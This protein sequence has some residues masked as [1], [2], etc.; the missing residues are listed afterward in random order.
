NPDWQERFDYV[1]VVGSVIS[2]EDERN[3]QML[4]EFY[5]VLKPGGKLYGSFPSIFWDLETAYLSQE[6]AYWLTDGSINLSDSAV[7]VPE[8]NHREIYYT[9]LRLNRIFKEAKFKRIGFEL[10]F[11]D[12]DILVKQQK[13][14][15]GIN[16][17][18]ICYWEFIVRLEKEKL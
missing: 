9:P 4:Q 13:E 10:F 11:A 17:P 2:S 5:K 8:Y 7:S 1:I 14:K 6:N 3:R 15:A 18:D 12:S 16:D